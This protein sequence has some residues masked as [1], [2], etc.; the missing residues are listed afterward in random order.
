VRQGD[1]NTDPYG[2]LARCPRSALLQAPVRSLLSLSF[3]S[4]SVLEK[5]LTGDLGKGTH[6]S[7]AELLIVVFYHRGKF[8]PN[9]ERISLV[10]NN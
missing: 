5:F 8:F 7:N 9:C 6:E 3:S 4:R 1:E 10:V 2:F